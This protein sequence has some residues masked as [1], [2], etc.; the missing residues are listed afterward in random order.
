MHIILLTHERELARPSNTGN[1][2][3]SVSGDECKLVHRRVWS[4]V[5]PDQELI[6]L[7][8]KESAGLVYPRT[9][10][11]HAQGAGEI[12]LAACEHFVL[13]DAT[14]QEARKMYNRSPYLR[15]AKTITLNPQQASRF[16][17]RRNQ[18]SGGLCTAECVVEILRSKG[19]T[20][21]ADQLEQRFIAF[22]ASGSF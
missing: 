11:G 21:L 6:Q 9:E 5:A 13:L 19:R 4:R 10:T 7:L 20:E 22:N 8:G 14:W 3:L 16:R 18:K 2:V 12:A 17:L 15:A 1:L